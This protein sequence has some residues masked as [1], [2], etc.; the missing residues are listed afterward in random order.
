MLGAA[1]RNRR[2]ALAREILGSVDRH[3]HKLILAGAGAAATAAFLAYHQLK[4]AGFELGTGNGQI[5]YTPVPGESILASEA[6]VR[7]A[8]MLTDT[9]MMQGVFV[10]GENNKCLSILGAGQM[11]RHGN[12]NSTKT[13]K[14]KF[15]VGSGGVN[16]ALNSR[17]AILC[18][19]QSK[20][21]FVDRLAYLTGLGTA[22]TTVVSTMGIFRKARPQ[23]ELRLA[24]CFP[25]PQGRSLKERVKEIRANCGWDLKTAAVVEEVPKPGHEELS[26][27]RWLAG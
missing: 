21:R 18:L 1:G 24:A 12:I 26:L 3:G 6:G 15:L 2:I 10:G 27:L 7:S 19:D 20:E 11:D 9:V 17:E 4:K 5:G 16:D 22:V 13:S 14:G 25:D 8:K 23:E